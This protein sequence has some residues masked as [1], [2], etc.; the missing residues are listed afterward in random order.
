MLATGLGAA[1][2]ENY[3]QGTGC[4]VA[5]DNSP[6]STTLSGDKSHELHKSMV[7]L[8]AIII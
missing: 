2:A 3:I 1:D 4:T 6:S 5:C 7:L 8:K